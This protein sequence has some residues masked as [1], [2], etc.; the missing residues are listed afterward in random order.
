MT[1]R[2]R[3]PRNF[4]VEKKFGGLSYTQKKIDSCSVYFKEQRTL[5]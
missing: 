5:N 1:A 2:I 3:W 4:P